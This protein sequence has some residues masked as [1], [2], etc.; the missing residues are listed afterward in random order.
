[1]ADLSVMPVADWILDGCW[2][3]M[4]FHNDCA[5]PV[6][7]SAM[8]GLPSSVEHGFGMSRGQ[9]GEEAVELLPS[10]CLYSSLCTVSHGSLGSVCLSRA[11]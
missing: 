3:S 8:E 9:L 1:M 11:Y 10:D 7:G 2:V 5:E 4:G 6:P